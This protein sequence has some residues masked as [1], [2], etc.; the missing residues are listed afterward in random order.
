MAAAAMISKARMS[1]N[2]ESI[3][4]RTGGGSRS[5]D[6]KCKAEN[7]SAGTRGLTHDGKSVAIF[8]IDEWWSIITDRMP[9]G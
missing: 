5:E 8:A 9:S 1:W 7:E 3:A 4:G 6:E 2:V